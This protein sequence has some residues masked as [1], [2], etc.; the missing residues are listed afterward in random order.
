MNKFFLLGDCHG[1]Y[2]PVHDFWE[3]YKHIESFNGSDVLITLG[4]LGT[5]Y[6]LDDANESSWDRT[7]KQELSKYPFVYYN[8]RGNHEQRPSILA[9]AAPDKW[10]VEENFGNIIYYEKDFPCIR[11]FRDDGGE[12]NIN[13]KKVLIIPGAYSVDKRYR[14]QRG[15]HWFAQEQLDDNE[16]ANIITN[17]AK[18]YDYIFAHTC[19]YSWEFMIQDLFTSS[20][21]QN[22]IDKTMEKFLDTVT[23]LT[24][25]QHFY[26]GH[27]HDNRDLKMFNATM[28]FHQPL[29]LGKF[30]SDL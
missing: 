22:S 28:L 4:D 6:F 15:Y 13:G 8:V 3:N 10:V 16:K 29:E 21:N 17:L 18:E 7:F 20:T 19:P 9:A 2:Q 26:F 25:Y 27:F 23:Q 12:Y 24:T 14:E 11:Y 5:L 1:N 30:Y